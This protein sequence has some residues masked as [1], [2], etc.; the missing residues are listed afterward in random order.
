MTVQEGAKILNVLAEFHPE[1]RLTFANNKVNVSK[2]VYDEK[3]ESVN[4]R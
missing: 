2:I 1:A 3:S 4:L